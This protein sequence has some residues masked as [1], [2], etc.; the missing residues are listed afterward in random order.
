MQALI[1]TVQVLAK[2]L[3]NFLPAIALAIAFGIIYKVL[4]SK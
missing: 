2:V 3:V 4:E 1:L